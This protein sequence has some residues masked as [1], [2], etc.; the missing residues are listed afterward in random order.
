M[1]NNDNFQ[2]KINDLN[3]E[4]ELGKLVY[5]LQE[6]ILALG[7]TPST[8]QQIS[9]DLNKDNARELYFLLLKAGIKYTGKNKKSK[10]LLLDV[11]QEFIDTVIIYDVSQMRKLMKVLGIPSI[12][13]ITTGI[14]NYYEVIEEP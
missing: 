6:K 14:A 12:T 8:D 7:Y 13:N 3:P 9:L 2:L 4:G 10:D 5:L 1:S 11:T